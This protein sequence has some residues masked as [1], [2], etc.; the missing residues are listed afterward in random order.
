MQRILCHDAVEAG[1]G[2]ELAAQAVVD[3]AVVLDDPV[4]SGVVLGDRDFKRVGD[5][6][7]GSGAV[8]PDLPVRGGPVDVELPSGGLVDVEEQPHV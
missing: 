2:A 1:V 4:L 5:V 6:V 8:F 7:S 3:I